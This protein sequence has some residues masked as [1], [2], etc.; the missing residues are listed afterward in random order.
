MEEAWLRSRL[1]SGASLEAIAREA[2]RSPSTVAYW[3]NKHGLASQHALRHAARGPV[4]REVLEALVEEG[5][6]IRDIAAQLERSAASIRHWLAR[7]ELKTQ[8][9]RYSLRGGPKPSQILRE[10][11]LHGWTEYVRT[12]AV[13]RYRCG[14]C[15]SE[16]VAARRR[17]IK[18]L[19][20]EEAGGACRLC[21][22]D[23]YVGAL[24]FHHRDPSRKTFAL[25]RQGV[26]RSLATA[27]AE[28]RK[29]VLLC[30]NCHAMVEA[31]LLLVP[32]GA[33]IEDDRAR[34]ASVRGSSMA[35]HSAVNRRVVGSSPTPGA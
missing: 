1:E 26:T 23:A 24:Q 30:A 35:E 4:A 9:A 2:G 33:D 25:S 7:Y 16:S 14:R 10:C 11:A 12:G 3:A 34:D 28:A 19:L 17:R 8:P 18:E 5:L 20:V 22:F 29:C 31:G 6:S 21:G 32:A 13:G 15:N 27:R